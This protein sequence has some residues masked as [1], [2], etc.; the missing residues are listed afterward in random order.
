MSRVPGRGSVSG[1]LGNGRGAGGAV[2]EGMG[3]DRWHGAPQKHMFAEHMSW[4]P[5]T[6]RFS[7][8]VTL[9]GR[10]PFTDSSTVRSLTS[11]PPLGA[12]AVRTGLAKGGLL[13]AH[14][15]RLSSQ[16]RA[17][18]SRR[19]ARGARPTAGLTAHGPRLTEQGARLT[20]HSPRLTAHSSAHGPHSWLTAHGAQPTAHG[21][22][23]TAH[24]CAP[25]RP[26]LQAWQKQPSGPET[27]P[28]S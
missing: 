20:V 18:G 23:P 6:S 27:L 5:G 1:G 26:S 12:W 14:G 22:R 3:K 8:V 11:V 7:S 10:P 19:T 17:H 16:S 2:R 9:L 28:G 15:S 25:G 21:P 24:G 4:F 13:T